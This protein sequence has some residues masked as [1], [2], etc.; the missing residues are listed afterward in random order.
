[1]KKSSKDAE[2]DYLSRTIIVEPFQKQ[3][4]SALARKVQYFQAHMFNIGVESGY[5]ERY[6][7]KKAGK[8]IT[9]LRKENKWMQ[10]FDHNHG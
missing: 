3:E 2:K 9:R 4:L 6:D 5:K 7:N 8:L 1:M 10:E